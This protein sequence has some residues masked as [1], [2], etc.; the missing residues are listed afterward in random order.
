MKKYITDEKTGLKYELAGDNEQEESCA[1]GKYGSL[2][3]E[4]VKSHRK[5]TYTALLTEFRLNEYLH[6]VDTQ[7]K[8]AVRRLTAEIAKKRGIDEKLKVSDPLHWVQEMNNCKAS[9]EEIVLNEIVYA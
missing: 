5:G 1:I 3:L 4:F 7:A 6:C 8:E 2:H 9:A